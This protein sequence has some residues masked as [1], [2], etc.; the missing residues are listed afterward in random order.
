MGNQAFR[1]RAFVSFL[2]FFSFLLSAL[3]GS[4]L[5]LRPEGSL[6]AWSGWSAL[7]LEKNAWEGLHAVSVFVFL[8]SAI[9]HLFYNWRPLVAGLRKGKAG[10]TH[11]WGESAAALLLAG[12]LLAGTLGKWLPIRWIV[13]LR[14][15]FKS[16]SAVVRVAPPVADAESRTLA[17]LGRQIG[18]DEARLLA[19]AAAAHIRVESPAQTLADVACKNGLS[20]EDVYI[21]L[22]GKRSANPSDK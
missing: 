22:G 10:K 18:M 12:L 8:L 21:L 2:L 14:A 19:A 11:A 3:S 4:V 13:D 17:E 7:G 9:G 1:W 20:P 5:F 15:W 6:A 16:G